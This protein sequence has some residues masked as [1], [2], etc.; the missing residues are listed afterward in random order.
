MPLRGQARAAKARG[1]KPKT[2]GSAAVPPA[3]RVGEILQ[4]YADRAVLRGYSRATSPRGA[5]A[6]Y[7]MV[8]HR[9][10]PFELTLDTQR[11]TLRVG[12]VLPQVSAKSAMYR[13][14]LDFV[15]VR[16]T[17]D[18]PE[19]RRIDPRKAQVAVENHKGNVWIT[20]TVRGGDYEYATRKL[21]NLMQEIF[22]IFLLD[23]FDYE[24]VAFDLDPDHP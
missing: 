2:P 21:I 3:T 10:R 5:P 12:V 19:H 6:T 14:L 17:S 24:V 18:M 13:Q 8:W 15:R 22:M 9:D 7:R 23:H 20:V 1:S 11:R 4:G 16:T